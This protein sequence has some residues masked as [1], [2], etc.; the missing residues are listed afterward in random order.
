MARTSS[1]PRQSRRLVPITEAADYAGVCSKTIRR[2]IGDGSLPGYRMGAR[3]IRVS[4]DD[5]DAL[6]RPIPSA[7]DR[8]QSGTHATDLIG[9]DPAPERA[10]G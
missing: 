4:L 10:S 3:L 5:L 9:R 1:P 6:L 2:R 8:S 7:V